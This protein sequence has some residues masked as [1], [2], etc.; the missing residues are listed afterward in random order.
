MNY[1]LEIILFGHI[2]NPLWKSH[3]ERRRIRGEVTRRAIDRRL[4]SYIDFIRD[5]RT[6]AEHEPCGPERIF[7]IWFQGEDAAPELVKACWRSVRK[8]C[9]QELVVLDSESIFQWIDLPEHIVRKWREGKM[10]PAH[11]SD[12]CRLALLSRYGGL[13]L[14]AT[15]YV[16]S[17][18]PEWLWQSD[19]FVYMSGSEKTGGWY[20]FIQN[21]FIRAKAGNFL[22]SAWFRLICEYWRREDKQVDYL[23]HQLLFKKLVEHNALASELFSAMPK[24]SQEP[25]HELWFGAGDGEYRREDW[26]AICAGAMFQKTEYKSARAISPILGSNAYHLIHNE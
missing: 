17:P 19:F 7:S 5:L 15:D 2:L 4:D 26:D 22:A 10:R 6:E 14:D 18:L 20:A 13:W 8:N 21:C 3:A 16:P 11:F 9:P 24:I 12:F 23:I 25:T 1:K